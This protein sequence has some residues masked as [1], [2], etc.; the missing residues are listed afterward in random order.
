MSTFA[1]PRCPDLAAKKSG[2][3]PDFDLMLAYAPAFSRSFTED[4]E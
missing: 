4:L 2:V 3:A 1:A